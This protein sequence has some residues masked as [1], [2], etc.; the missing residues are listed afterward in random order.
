MNQIRA[1]TNHFLRMN[2]PDQSGFSVRNLW[3]MK[4]FYVTYQQYERLQALPAEYF[5]LDRGVASLVNSEE[6]YLQIIN[7]SNTLK[8]S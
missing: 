3:N 1:K 2:Y 5:S 4:R 8:I 6:S 7:E